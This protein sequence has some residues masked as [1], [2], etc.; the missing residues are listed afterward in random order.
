M[1]ATFQIGIGQPAILEKDSEMDMVESLQLEQ[2]AERN[3]LLSLSDSNVL[4]DRSLSDSKLAEWK[5]YRQSLRDLDF[6]DPN[7]ITWPSKP[8]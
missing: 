2:R 1:K 8:E 3:N 5:T 7:N 4:P 6:S